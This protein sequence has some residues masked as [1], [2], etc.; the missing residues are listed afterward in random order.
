MSI[1]IVILVRFITNISKNLH[2]YVT[3]NF[4]VSIHLLPLTYV[5]ILEASIINRYADITGRLWL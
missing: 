4:L 5:L 1:L 2:N 3:E